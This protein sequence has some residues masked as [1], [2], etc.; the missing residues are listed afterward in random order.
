MNDPGPIP[1]FLDRNRA[2]PLVFSYTFLNTYEICP[3]QCFR[4]YIRKDI[5][6]V[7]TAQ[8]KW[9]NQVHSAMEVRIR[10]G[11][12][13][14]YDMHKWENLAV[15]FVG[16]SAHIEWQLGMTQEG[17]PADYWGDKAPV[18]LRGKIDCAVVDTTK[19]YIADW[20]TGKTRE[21]PFELEVGAL[22]LKTAIPSLEQ[23][24][25]RYAWLAEDRMGRLHDLSDTV[26][27]RQRVDGI[28]HRIEA[29]RAAGHFE[30]REGPLCK[31][32][33]VYDCEFNRNPDRP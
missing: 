8:M 20:K 17:K 28:V 16:R 11:K 33:N 15:P 29:D 26:R 10:A 2:R 1:A 5:P 32:C 4:R 12:P 24:V 23:I 21:D 7:E 22:L 30:K 27:T 3:H 13:L 9:G 14:P 19:A 25:G 31:W 18:Y 6:Y